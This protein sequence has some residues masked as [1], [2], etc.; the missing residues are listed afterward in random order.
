MRMWM[1]QQ[2]DVGE[3][4]R[5]EFGA[6][7]HGSRDHRRL[8]STGV[9]WRNQS[10]AG[11]RHGRHGQIA[12]CMLDLPQCII[13]RTVYLSQ[14][15]CI[16]TYTAAAALSSLLS[17]HNKAHQAVR[18]AVSSKGIGDLPTLH[19]VDSSHSHTLS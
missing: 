18:V 3:L 5:G 16:L 13:M 14:A 2:D 19:C 10:P 7:S 15:A 9:D 11:C 8:L 6:V 1:R 17:A 12:N 4:E